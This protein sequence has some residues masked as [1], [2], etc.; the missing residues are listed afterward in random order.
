MSHR[1]YRVARL[2]GALAFVPFVVALPALSQSPPVYQGSE[3]VVTAGRL[4]Q[5]LADSLRSVVVVTARDIEAS[6]QL[7]LAQVLQ[8]YGG[9]ETATSGG[10]GSATS[11]F[12]RGSN[13]SHALVLVDGVRVGSATL[14]TTAIENIPLGQIERIEIVSGPASGLYGSDA[15]GGVIQIFT[16]SGSRSPGGSVVA[17]Y[18]TW[19]TRSLRAQLAGSEGETSYSLAAGYHE[20]DGYNATRPTISFDRY[21]PDDD[22]YRNTN[23]SAKLSHRF[24]DRHEIGAA[25][26][27]SDG[28]TGFDNGPATDDRTEQTLSTVSVFSRNR[29]AERWES[30]VRLARG[31]DDSES[32]G[33]FPDRFRTDQ[34]QALWQNTFRLDG[35]SIVAGLEYLGQKVDATTAY[36]ANKRTVRSA[37]AGYVGEFGSHALEANIRRDDNSQFGSPTTGSIAYGFQVAQGARLRAAYGQGFHAPSFNDLY[38]PGFGN[39]DLKPER[40]R[41]GEVGLQVDRASQRFTATAFDNRIEDLIVFFYDPATQVFGPANLAKARIRGMELAWDGRI[42]DVRL[43]A[44]G[45]FQDPQSEDTGKQLPRRAR[46][47]GSVLASRGFGAWTVGAE[48]VASSHRFETADEAPASRMAGYAIANLTLSWALARQWQADLRWNNVTDKDYE[49]VQGYRTPGS[50]VFLSLRWTPGA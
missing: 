3:T 24:G 19:N 6:G 34:D 4:E 21:N 5:R 49:Q 12:L 37:F 26:L 13:S 50:N 30:L 40:S 42:A 35:Q 38:Y 16:R 14:G 31:R 17:G 2:R 33:A 22:G 32:V 43:R 25:V 8:Q 44:K 27:H 1:K 36:D 11:I 46:Q 9:V 45:T 7:S 23:V 47:F 39:P 15:I 10:I 48:V 20:T 28:R 29:L 18:G 41:S